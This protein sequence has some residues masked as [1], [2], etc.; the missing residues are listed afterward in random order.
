M[1]FLREKLKKRRVDMGLTL[2]E[3]ADIVGVERPTVQRYESGKISKIDTLTVEKLADAVR[4]N[5]AYLVGWTDNPSLLE[6]STEYSFDEKKVIEDYRSLSKEGQEK[7]IEY[8][9][10]LIDSGKYSAFSYKIASRDG[11]NEIY[12]DSKQKEEMIKVVNESKD[13]DNSDLY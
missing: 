6:N 5:P 11:K 7:A 1:P 10:D 12:L 9:N 3:I 2:Q 4:C 13:D 8:I